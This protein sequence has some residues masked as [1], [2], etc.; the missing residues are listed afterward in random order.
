LIENIV[1]TP[2][3]LNSKRLFSITEGVILFSLVTYAVFA[4]HSIAVTQAAFLIGLFAWGIQLV[5]S[6]KLSQKRTPIDIAIFGFFACCV[7]SSFFSYDP[8]VSIKGLKSPA[9][10]FAFYFVCNKVTTL[11]LARF[12]AFA[13]V[14]SCLVNVAY[15]AG[16]IAVG[17]GLRIDS[18]EADSPLAR[19]GLRVGDVLLEADGKQVTTLEEMLQIADTQRGR[20]PIK[21]QRNESLVEGTVSRRAVRKADDEGAGRLGITVSPGRNFRVTGLYSHYETYA[22]VLQLIAALAIGLLIAHPVKRSGRAW[23]LAVSVLLITITL[24]LTSTRAAMIGLAAAAAAMALA[25]S[26]KRTVAIAILAIVVMAPAAMFAIERSRGSILFDP[27]EGSTAYRLEVWRE[28]LGLIKDHPLLGIGKGSEARLKEQLGLYDDGRLPPGHFHSTPIQIAAWWGLPA[29]VFY[30][31]LMAILIAEAWRLSRRLKEQNRHGAWGISIGVLGALVA[32]NV[33]SLVHFNFGDGEV[34]MMIWLLTGLLLAVR[35]IVSETSDETRTTPTLSQTAE[36]D[37][38][39][40]RPRELKV[41]SGSS[42]Q[43]AGARPNS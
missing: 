35:R 5:A 15:S 2:P 12:L 41:A 14:A 7:L 34:V 11:K 21:Y 10:F 37:L 29:L 3:A 6:G 22:E 40:S 32:F 17:R 9:L 43:A 18:I 25:S 28:A 36:E 13:I 8:L 27:Q 23:F 30:F 19:T 31:S 39:R 38:G 4:P 24:L 42:A 20:I 16:Q 26:R 1:S 33:S